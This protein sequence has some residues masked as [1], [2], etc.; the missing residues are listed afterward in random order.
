MDCFISGWAVTPTNLNYEIIDSTKIVSEYK[1]IENISKNINKIFPEK[2]QTLVAWSMGAIIVL[3]CMHKIKAKKIILCS[4]TLKFV[5]N[6]YISQDLNRLR[7]N[8]VINKETAIKS[9]YRKCGVPKDSIDLNYYTAEELLAG[10][11]FLEKTEIREII[12]PQCCEISIICGENDK[13]ISQN[14][15]IKVAQKLCVKP[16]VIPNANHFDTVVYFQNSSRL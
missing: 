9:F 5:A 14:Q 15:S 1:N 10:L 7:Q 4:P 13:I 3:G 6:D 16:T 12:K 11:D 2:I 8:V